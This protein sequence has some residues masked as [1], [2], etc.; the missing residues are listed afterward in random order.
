MRSLH[1]LLELLGEA[2]KASWVLGLAINQN[3][4]VQV[5]T[6][7]ASRRAREADVLPP[8]DLVAW[9]YER[10]RK[11]SVSADNTIVVFYIN[12][13]TVS[14]VVPNIHDFSKACGSYFSTEILGKI[15]S[16]VHFEGVLERRESDSE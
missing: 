10:S 5:W 8:N 4:E 9:M 1:Q 14:A 12:H 13:Q 3:F 6:G 16:F 11:M 7:G 2:Q 15:D